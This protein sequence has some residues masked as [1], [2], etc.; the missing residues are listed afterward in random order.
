MSR[1]DIGSHSDIDLLVIWD[2][3]MPFLKRL[4]VF[5]SAIQPDVAMDILVYTPKEI[6]KAAQINTFIR[7]AIQEGEVLYEKWK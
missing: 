4:D 5:S 1:D 2:T 7:K 3:D 6:T